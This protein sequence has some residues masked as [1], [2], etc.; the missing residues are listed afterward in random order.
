MQT[1]KQKTKTQR[2]GADVAFTPMIIADSF[3]RSQYAR[4]SEFSTTINQYDNPLIV[5]FAGSDPV[6]IAQASYKVLNY[7]DGIDLNCGCP[8]SWAVK[9]HIG[10]WM[11]TQPQLIKDIIK[12]TYNM[13]G[14]LAKH[15]ME[16]LKQENEMVN[17]VLAP[18]NNKIQAKKEHMNGNCDGNNTTENNENNENRV[19][20]KQKKDDSCDDDENDEN[21][22]D[23]DYER[24]NVFGSNNSDMPSVGVPF[25]IKIR[26][27]DNIRETIDLIK[28]AQ[29][30]G[31]AWVTV[32]GRTLQQRTRVPNSV[33]S[34]LKIVEHTNGLPIIANGDINCQNDIYNVI[35]Q[36]ACQ[37]VMSARGILSNPAMFYGMNGIYTNDSVIINRISKFKNDIKNIVLIDNEQKQNQKYKQNEN[38]N[39]QNMND[40]CN[41]K[42]HSLPDINIS[43]NVNAINESKMN[44]I[45]INCIEN[46]VGGCVNCDCNC[47]C[48]LLS[49]NRKDLKKLFEVNYQGYYN[50]EEYDKIEYSIGR[51]F[52]NRR[53]SARRPPLACITDYL[54]LALQFGGHFTMH[55][56]H[57]MYMLSTHLTKSEKRDFNTRKSMIGIIDF[58]NQRGWIYSDSQ[59]GNNNKVDIVNSDLNNVNNNSHCHRFKKPW[60]LDV[61]TSWQNMNNLKLLRSTLFT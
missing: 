1:Q 59:N 36:T 40:K 19:K 7:S 37:G 30:A 58:F 52:E 42:C 25:S 46:N 43:N 28:Q 16:K 60:M 48:D 50:K 34:I 56:H 12:T 41:C 26:I 22:D 31:V 47:N 38:K 35:S 18:K 39:K 23:D 21:D 5:Q 20:S 29:Q 4:D 51:T 13:Y 8:Q 61:A 54:S 11:I 27:H 3:N 57:L 55:H 49:G 9:E 17:D 45:D 53:I 10:A 14:N 33:S 44:A 32:H 24:L 15:K 6:T 2:W